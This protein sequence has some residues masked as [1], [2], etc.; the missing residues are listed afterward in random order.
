MSKEKISF[1]IGIATIN[2]YNLLKSFLLKYNIQFPLTDI[3]IIDN[4]NQGIKEDKEL[5]GKL[6]SVYVPQSPL[7]VA[8]SWNYLCKAIFQIHTH[9]FILND[10]VWV[11]KT[12]YELYNYLTLWQDFN[13]FVSQKGYCS[14]VISKKCFKEIGQFDENFKGAYFEDN[15]YSR[16]MYLS[17]VDELRTS[18]LNPRIY[19]ESSSIKKDQSLNVNFINNAEY[20]KSKWGGDRGGESFKTP[21]NK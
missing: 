10:D 16:R 2:Q 14:F 20:Y 12:E 8:A 13:F 4:G 15:D 1:A 11:D 19:N 18:F 7:S 9:A 17:K 5:S 21:F 6:E 3:F